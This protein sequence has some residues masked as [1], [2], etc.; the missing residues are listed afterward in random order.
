[1]KPKV[2]YLH[3]RSYWLDEAIINLLNYCYAFKT[4]LDTAFDALRIPR[5]NVD[6]TVPEVKLYIEHLKWLD[7]NAESAG[8]RKYIRSRLY[9]VMDNPDKATDII[10][11]VEAIAAM[12][13]VE[14]GVTPAMLKDLSFEELLQLVEKTK[15]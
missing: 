1:M 7:E 3:G 5:E 15:V 12:A 9:N 10:K 4:T 14:V 11:A 13:L 2:F 8:E 6:T